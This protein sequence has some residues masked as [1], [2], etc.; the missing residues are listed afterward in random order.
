MTDHNTGT[1]MKK[2]NDQPFLLQLK[3]STERLNKSYKK[4]TWNEMAHHLKISKSYMSQILSGKK[5]F[6]VEYLDALVDFLDLDHLA[7]HELLQAYLQ[8]EQLRLQKKSKY[9]SRYI[10]TTSQEHLELH[11]KPLTSI[12]ELNTQAL[13][14]FD[15][16]YYTALL[17]L[18]ETKDFHLDFDW[19][20]Q[21]LNITKTLAEI[22]WNLLVSKGYAIPTKDGGWKKSQKKFRIVVGDNQKSNESDI[23][24]TRYNYYSQF[25][26]L[27]KHQILSGSSTKDLRLIQG[28]T[29][30]ANT[31]KLD[32]AKLKLEKN[33]YATSELLAEEDCDEVYFLMNIAIPITKKL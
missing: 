12:A 33:L 3:K 11:Q 22:S 29:C 9:L 14:L 16:W 21:R 6:P 26:E 10:K 7:K 8:D 2:L 24:R 25:M 4:F 30:S 1:K 32:E 5:V 27:A 13:D 28:I 17:D 18:V 15:R 23:V 20:A 31:E 19:F